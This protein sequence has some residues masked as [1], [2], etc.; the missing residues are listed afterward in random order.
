MTETRITEVAPL[1]PDSIHEL[2]GS[3]GPCITLLLPPYRPGEQAKSMAAIIKTDLQQAGK[4]LRL[5]KI[6][7]PVIVDLLAPLEHLTGE[8]EFLAGTH[9]GRAIFRAPDVL[10]QFELLGP[11]NQALAI[12]GCF[13]IRPFLNE[14]HL[15]PEFYILKLSKK[16]IALL[17]CAHLRAIEISL[18]KS[19]PATA[20]QVLDLDQ[21]DHDL[22]NRSAIGPSAGNMRGVSFGTGSGRETQHTY[23]AD[24]YKAVDRG[25][26]EFLHINKAPLVLA[27]V[28]EDVAAYQNISTYPQLLE[29]AIQ[30]SPGGSMSEEGLVERAY[31]LVQADCTSRAAAELAESRERLSP[32]RFFTNFDRILPAALEGRIHRLYLDESAHKFG[33]LPD[34]KR[35]GRWNW[36]E[37]DLLN[38]AAVETILQRGSVFA[39]PTSQMPDRALAAAVLR[40]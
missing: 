13:Q 39:L 21:P 24:F 2:L 23:L 29:E 33:T 31:A 30:G 4:Q 38:V 8:E 6:P 11:V 27:G 5:R 19:I 3:A 26:T 35:G 9:C 17:R 10:R 22:K 37:E 14:L 34:V 25:L 28:V 32:A 12:G 16:R 15:P 18:L 40:F 1:R 20:E 7:E 36:G